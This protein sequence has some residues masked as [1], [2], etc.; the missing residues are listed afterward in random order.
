MSGRILSTIFCCILLAMTACQKYIDEDMPSKDD[1]SANLNKPNGD[2]DSDKG[3]DESS[4]FVETAHHVRVLE[5]SIDENRTYVMF[6]SMKEYLLP[7][8]KDG[9]EEMA[10]QYAKA[11]NEGGV[12]GW[13]I[14][15]NSDVIA[16]K[17]KYDVIGDDDSVLKSLNKEFADYGGEP[18][19]NTYNGKTKRFLC[20][21]KMDSTYNLLHTQ[22]KP[23]KAG[24]TVKYY[25]RLV[26]DTIIRT[27]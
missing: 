1:T 16:V 9:G 6:M 10:A 17:Q 20:A 15:W 24:Q 3:N 4:T 19:Y 14:P 11:Y 23:I 21:E 5:E 12:T 22:T 13:R 27:E 25:L 8:L 18:F 2:K 7:T 26:K